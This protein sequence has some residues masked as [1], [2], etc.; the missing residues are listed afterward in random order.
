MSLVQEDKEA[1]SISLS[2][3][4]SDPLRPIKN[5]ASILRFEELLQGE[6][7]S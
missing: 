6:P 4:T 3:E 1:L 2:S 7:T 5:L